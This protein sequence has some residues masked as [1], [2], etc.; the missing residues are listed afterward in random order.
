MSRIEVQKKQWEFAVNILKEKGISLLDDRMTLSGN[1]YAIVIHSEDLV[2]TVSTIK[3]EGDD[4]PDKMTVY[5]PFS[6]GQV[7]QIEYDL[8]SSKKWEPVGYADATL[9][10]GG[11]AMGEFMVTDISCNLLVYPQINMIELQSL[12][13]IFNQVHPNARTM[14]IFEDVV[15]KRLKEP[16]LDDK[17]Q[18]ATS[19]TNIQD[20]TDKK[21]KDVLQ[22]R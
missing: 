11:V 10:P 17:I 12:D 7:I 2:I 4:K 9:R 22:E 1:G 15:L 5:S 16:S 14:L 13:Y 3:H 6:V 20:V 19:R 8:P 21:M 18:S